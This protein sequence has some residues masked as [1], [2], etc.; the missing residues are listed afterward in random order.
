MYVHNHYTG[1]VGGRIPPRE[2]DQCLFM[3]CLKE[4]AILMYEY[5]ILYL[6]ASNI[7]YLH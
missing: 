6:V 7:I 5:I 2:G 1:Y 4:I 3:P